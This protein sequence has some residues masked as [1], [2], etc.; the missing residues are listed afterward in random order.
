MEEW[1]ASSEWSSMGCSGYKSEWDCVEG[2]GQDAANTAFKK[3]WQTWI[4][5]DDIARMVSYGLN[6]IRV[7]H[8]VAVR[9][10]AS[11]V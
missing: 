2:I 10:M 3:H 9:I 5:E 4:T 6:T 8:Q 11:L 1:M 7:R